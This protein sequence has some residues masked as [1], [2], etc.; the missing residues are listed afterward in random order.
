MIKILQSYLLSLYHLVIS[1]LT[2]S[3]HALKTQCEL[4]AF[5]IEKGNRY[6]EIVK[7]YEIEFNRAASQCNNFEA[8]TEANYILNKENEAIERFHYDNYRNIKKIA[9]KIGVNAL[10]DTD[11]KYTSVFE[12]EELGDLK[13]VNVEG[14]NIILEAIR[15]EL[16]GRMRVTYS[17]LTLV[18]SFI[19]AL[20]ASCAALRSQ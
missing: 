15:N 5:L 7:Y 10:D 3:S 18:F 8:T 19:A 20:A 17:L 4:N 1:N 12:D 14:Q 13:F 6:S 2:I 11:N 16:A 9:E